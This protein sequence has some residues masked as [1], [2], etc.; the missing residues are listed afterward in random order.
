MSCDGNFR[1]PANG[2]AG[3]ETRFDCLLL[4]WA[5]CSWRALA[6]YDFPLLMLGSG[7]WWLPLAMHSL[8]RFNNSPLFP[9]SFN[10]PHFS[11]CFNCSTVYSSGS[12]SNFEPGIPSSSVR[13]VKDWAELH[14]TVIFLY[15]ALLELAGWAVYLV[16]C[17]NLWRHLCAVCPIF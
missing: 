1:Q 2:I 4:S 10:P 7:Y 13:I 8:T 17:P 11:H 3:N 6:A 9:H 15:T 16:G 5:F 14:A 12:F